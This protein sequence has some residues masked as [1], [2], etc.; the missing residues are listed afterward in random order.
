MES[1]SHFDNQLICCDAYHH[2]ASH[3][4]GLEEFFCTQICIFPL[5]DLNVL[6]QVVCIAVTVMRF[7]HLSRHSFSR[8]WWPNTH[9]LF[10]QVQRICRRISA[11]CRIYLNI[12]C[13]FFPYSVPAKQNVQYSYTKLKHILCSYFR[14]ILYSVKYG[15]W[16]LFF[17]KIYSL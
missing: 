3:I 7:L 5:L 12:R 1:V 11:K 13:K 17:S 2:T 14:I 9:P 6:F 15:M 10:I 8:L 4:L 16:P